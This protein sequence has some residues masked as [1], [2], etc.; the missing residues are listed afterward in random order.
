MFASNGIHHRVEHFNN[1]FAI[2]KSDVESD[3]FKMHL[4]VVEQLNVRCRLKWAADH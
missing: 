4:V 1:P 2:G 3:N